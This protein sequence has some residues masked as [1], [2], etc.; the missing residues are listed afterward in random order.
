MNKAEVK[1]AT[2]ALE[3]LLVAAEK[4]ATDLKANRAKAAS[5]ED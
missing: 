1:K 3:S 5:L 4:K 2:A